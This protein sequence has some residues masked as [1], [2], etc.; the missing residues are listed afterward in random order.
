MRL[1]IVL[2]MA[3]VLGFGL[4][5]TSKNASAFGKHGDGG[6][7]NGGNGGQGGGGAPGGGG[8]GGAPEPISMLLLAAGGGVAGVKY[9]KRRKA[10]KNDTNRNL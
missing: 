1:P 5:I 2:I 8:G 6:S 7:S 10:D 3:L 4:C 9:L